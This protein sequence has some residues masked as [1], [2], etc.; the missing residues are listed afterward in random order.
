MNVEIFTLCESATVENGAVSIHRTKELTLLE[1]RESAMVQVTLV[2]VLRFFPDEEGMHAVRVRF[3]DV[4]G[5]SVFEAEAKPFMIDLQAM[6]YDSWRYIQQF[7][8]RF[9]LRRGEHRCTL[10]VDDAERIS[11]P[12]YVE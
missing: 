6:T 8:F 1:G 10:F 5:Q 11:I 4:D 3:E 2:C 7:N 12:Y 9:E